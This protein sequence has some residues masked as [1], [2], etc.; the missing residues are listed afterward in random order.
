MPHRGT[1]TDFEL[2]TIERL[3]GQDY[4][5]IH[6]SE[7]VREPAEVVLRDRLRDNLQR[8]Y[9]ELPQESIEEA[10]R[11]FARPDGVDTLRRNMHFHNL[12]RRGDDKLPVLRPD[13]TTEFRHIYAVDWDCPENNDFLVVNQLSVQGKSN[14]RRPDL[15]VYINGLPLILFEL[16]NPYDESPTVEDALNQ[17]EHYKIDIPQ[18]FDY[19]AISIVSDGVTTLHGMWTANAEWYAPWKSIDGFAIE[20]NTTGSMKTLIEGLFPKARLLRYIR[21]FIAFEVANDQVVKKGAKYHQFFAVCLAAT[22]TIEALRNNSEDK[23]IGVIWHTT[24]SGK[25]LSMAFLVGS[26][27]RE[28]GINPTFVIQVDRTDLDDQL[29]DQ[30][31]AVGSLVG[32]V[33]QAESTDQLREMLQTQGGEVIFSTIEKF[34]LKGEKEDREIEHPVLSTRSDIVVVADEAHR[35][36]YGFDEG[37]ARN[38]AVALPNAKRLGFTGTPVSFSGADTTEVFGDVIHTYD[39]R[40]AQADKATVPIYYEPRQAKLHLNKKDLDAE[41]AKIVGTTTITDLDRRKAQWAALAQAAGSENRVNAIAQD[42]LEHFTTRNETQPGKALVVCMTRENCVRLYD[43]LTKLPG[44]PEVKIIMTG[45][46]AKDPPA[47]NTAGH[48]TTKRARDKIKSRMKNPLDPLKIVIVCDMWLTGTD[49]PC[50][51]TLYIDKPMQGHTIIQAI[52]RVNR[53]FSDK[54]AGL[55]VDYIGIG[56]ELREAANTYSRGGGFGDPA[57]NVTDTAVPIF[58][59]CLDEIRKLLPPG[60]D[61]GDWQRLSRIELE[62]RYSLVFGH[63]TTTDE[64]RDEYLAAELRLSRAYLLVRHLDSCRSFAAEVIFNQR[65]RNQL[66]RS[67]PGRTPPKSISQAVRDLV[68]DSIDSDAVVDIFKVSGIDKV[69][70]SILDDA[71]LQTFKD[72]PNINLRLKLLEK[73]I[74]DEIKYRERKNVA[75]AKSF[76]DLLDKTL[77]EYNNRLIDAAAVVKAM[78]AIRNDIQNNDAR[79][80]SLGLSEEELAFYDSVAANYEHVYGVQLLKDLIHDVVKSI[81][82][83]L[84]VDWTEPHREDVKAAVRAAV[85]RVLRAKGVQPADFDQFIVYI[86]SQAEALFADWPNAT[87]A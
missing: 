68:D 42:L 39:I 34:R 59:T 44:C 54:P 49:I 1:E 28:K 11:R 63:L 67:I 78:I 80:E 13:G 17:I 25:S 53:V 48:I 19:N 15:V 79:A 29:F 38:L 66:L 27:R 52:S 35:T 37:Y 14:D 12:L 4:D 46:I 50:L 57:P 36:Q 9:P 87:A 6:G 55:V 5:Y 2:T 3:I 69:D 82:R 18:I 60:E 16:K 72:R 83:N 30:F 21:D 56:D 64:K 76:R 26:V 41:L 73:L 77:R 75:L 22:K 47:W 84:K 51:S 43:A 62:D 58:K 10:V 65:V 71:F 20:A 40:Q 85:R 32:D 33:K 74:R 23:R 7:L 70:I 8:R 81:K 61:Y 24:G 45:N 86:M 31:V